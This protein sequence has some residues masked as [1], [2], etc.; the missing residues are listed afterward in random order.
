MPKRRFDR[1]AVEM[2]EARVA[3]RLKIDGLFQTPEVSGQG[4]VGIADIGGR[5]AVRFGHNPGCHA[6][7]KYNRRQH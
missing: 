6:A 1:H 7:G 3:G 5:V 2:I 4:R